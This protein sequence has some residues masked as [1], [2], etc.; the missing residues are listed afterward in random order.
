MEQA[1]QVFAAITFLAIGVSHLAQPKAWVEFYQTLAAHGTTGV[2]FEG[3]LCLNFGA[4][5]VAFHNVWSGPALLLTVVGLVQI[6]KGAI[7]FVAPQVVLRAMQRAT[8][9]RAWFFQFGGVVA[10][11]VSGYVWWLRFRL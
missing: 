4:F 1:V 11:L 7:R 6:L 8:P 9:E 2:F 3:F 5:I 10:L